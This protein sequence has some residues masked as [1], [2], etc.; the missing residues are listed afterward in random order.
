ATATDA[1]GVTKA[2][3]YW[4]FTGAVIP[5]DGSIAGVTCN[6]AGNKFTWTFR[7]G[8]GDRRFSVKAY[9]AANNQA[10]T[11][12]RLLHLAQGM[13]PVTPAP[14]TTP[15]RSTPAPVTS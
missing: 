13:N 5:C 11:P 7:V 14:T 9:D 8:A 3:L 10:S 4:A 15:P 6:V 1:V 2:E 12:E